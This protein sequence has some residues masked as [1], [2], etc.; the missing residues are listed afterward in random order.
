M[1]DSN[2]M[3]NRTLLRRT[4][5]TVGA[6]VGA[7]VVVVGT[8]TLVAAAVVGHAVSPPGESDKGASPTL[9]PAGNV[10]GTTPVPV[11]SPALPLPK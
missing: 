10:H 8:I 6:M 2:T 5:V 4:F 11:P 1:A 7:C 9:V 3:D